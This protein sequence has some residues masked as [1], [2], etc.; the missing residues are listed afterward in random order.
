MD[1][2]RY[3]RRHV[4]YRLAEA[5][6]MLLETLRGGPWRT[7]LDVGCGDGALLR[8]LKGGG[9][10]D[11][12]AAGGVDLSRRRVARARE[13]DPDLHCR[14]DS[15]ETLETVPDASVDRYVSTQVIEHVPDE[16]AM[17][18]SMRRVLRPGGVAYVSTVF[19]R[20]WAWYFYRCNGRWTLDPT[21]LREYTRDGQLLDR[22]RASGLETVEQ[23]K[24]PIRY[25]LLDFVLRA[26][27]VRRSDI[28]AVP[29]VDLLRQIELP[30]PGYF[31]WE[32]L[33]RRRPT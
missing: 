9:D 30:V 20:P 21:H 11:G 25:P 14:V 1:I 7:L 31:I 23:R 16:E 29:L 3:A 17:I 15:A 28:A 2:E 33:C 24:T 27:G 10:L 26:A 5:P 13:I 22:L 12:K 18:R 6:E 8:A 19:K 32:I 4:H